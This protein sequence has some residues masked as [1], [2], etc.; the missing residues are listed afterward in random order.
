MRKVKEK[1]MNASTQGFRKD[2]LCISEIGT[3]N[4]QLR[5]PAPANP[6]KIMFCLEHL[7]RAQNIVS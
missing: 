4:S 3:Q 1:E 7:L 2:Q 6:E 5:I